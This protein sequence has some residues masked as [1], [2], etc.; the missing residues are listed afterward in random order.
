VARLSS[1]CGGAAWIIR[2]T[3]DRRFISSEHVFMRQTAYYTFFI[4]KRNEVADLQISLVTDILQ[5]C[6]RNWKKCVEKM[7]SVR[8]LFN[9]VCKR[10]EILCVTMPVIEQ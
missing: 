9:N 8:V 2:Q 10:T 7:S 1:S 3:D 6:K 4:C 5:C